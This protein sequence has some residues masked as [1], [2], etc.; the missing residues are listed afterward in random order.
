MRAGAASVRGDY[1]GADPFVGGQRIRPGDVL[2]CSRGQVP[3]CP[4]S[5]AKPAGRGHIR[6]L[7]LCHLHTRR[8]LRFP[9]T[10]SWVG[11]EKKPG[12]DWAWETMPRSVGDEPYSGGYRTSVRKLGSGRETALPEPGLPG[13]VQTGSPSTKTHTC[14]SWAPGSRACPWGGLCALWGCM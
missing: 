1:R 6:L 12:K 14:H 11:Y 5:L 4:A 2:K 9:R 10:S 8:S 7:T 3:R 13:P